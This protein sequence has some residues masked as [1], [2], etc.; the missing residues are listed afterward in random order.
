MFI[1]VVVVVVVVNIVAVAAVV[2]VVGGVVGVIVVEDLNVVVG[3]G[4]QEKVV[5]VIE[6][7]RASNE[8]TL[9]HQLGT[10]EKHV[11]SF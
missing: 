6:R 4:M 10:A 5:V 2:V 8:R 7:G 9:G 3:C 1:V 11:A